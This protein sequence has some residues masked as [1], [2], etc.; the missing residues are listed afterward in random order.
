MGTWGTGLFEND[1]A[2]DWTMYFL[3]APSERLLRAASEAVIGIE[4][5]IER[6]LGGYALAAAEVVAAAN[7]RPSRDIPPKLRNCAEVNQ[8]VATPELA[9]QAM[10]AID[11]VMIAESSEIAELSWATDTLA[12]DWAVWVYDLRLR[13]AEAD[14][15]RLA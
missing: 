12:A 3:D 9:G 6:D 10:A 15:R 8:G 13:L 14:E 1:D 5:Y 4:D 11:R 7:G 2:G